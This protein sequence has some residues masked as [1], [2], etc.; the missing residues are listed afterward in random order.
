MK[1]LLFS[2]PIV[3]LLIGIFMLFLAYFFGGN[4]LFEEQ[5]SFNQEIRPIL[6]K[7]CLSCHGGVRKLGD[8]SLLFE[9]EAFSETESGEIAIVR[10]N[11]KASEVFKRITHHDPEERMPQKADP[12]S[13]EE[14]ELIAKWI[15]QGAKWEEHW[16]YIPPTQPK[17]PSIR[18]NWTKDDI[19]KYVLKALQKLDLKPA[20]ATN[21]ATYLRRASLDLTGLPPT[22][23]A[24]EA[25]LQDESEDAFEKAIDALLAS[26]HYGERWAAMWLDLARYADSQGY[27]KDDHRT[28][29]RYR[30]WVIQAFNQDMPFDQFTIEQLAGDLLEKPS[31]D[32]LVATGFHRNTM[33][34]AEGGT[35]D[36]EFRVASVIDRVN[37]TFELWQSSTMACVQ[38]HSH[39][40]DPIRHEEYYE[41]LDIFNQT[42][43]ADL[44]SE[45]PLLK[46]FSREDSIQV[47]E[48]IDFLL[49]K[50]KDLEVDRS[51]ILQEQITQA[52]FPILRP[53]QN[54]D[55]QNT[56]F[57]RGSG[58]GKWDI[59]SNQA[60]NL[61]AI[62]DNKFRLLFKDIELD[63]LTDITLR[64]TAKGTDS[65]IELRLD[66]A[67]GE[68]LAEINLPKTT[69]Q[70]DDGFGIPAAKIPIKPSQGKH[71]L[72]FELINTTG[73]IPDGIVLLEQI[74]LHYAN[75]YLASDELRT[76]KL[77]L[78][79]LKDQA[80]TA[81]IML[82]KSKTFR[83]ATKVFDR[84]N[85]R[86]Q[87]E[88]VQSGIPNAFAYQ[89][90]QEPANRLAFA[91]WLV[92]KDNPLTAR[93]MA[94]RIW[95][96][97]FGTGIIES[98]EDLGT[99]S[100]T[101]SH[102]ELLDYLAVQFQDKHQWGMK[103]FLKQIM[104]SATYRQSSKTTP[105]KLEKDPYNRYFSRGP[106]FRLSAEQIRDQALAVS[107]LL[108]DTIG[109]PSVMPH[110][111]DGVWQVVY[112]N[113]K[114]ITPKGKN[115]YRRG[116]YTYWKRTAPYPSMMAFDSP[117]REVCV[118]RRI[119]T[120]TPLQ[121]LV[122]LNDPVYLEAAEALAKKMQEA[123]K[124]NL[125]MAIQT[126][127]QL[128]LGKNPDEE[129][130][131]ILKQLYQQAKEDLTLAETST[132]EVPIVKVSQVDEQQ[133]S[134]AP[135]YEEIKHPMTVVANAIMNLDGFVMKE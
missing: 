47:A 44:S 58:D 12:L 105:E 74:E 23:S 45:Q 95:E 15:D 92:S 13:Q 114:W 79:A 122:T 120:N 5:V 25:F 41:T 113:A 29:W 128:A 123:G 99:Q 89:L 115:R 27:E 124:E 2:K 96:Q 88:A 131:D 135:Y 81:Q 121:A 6:N 65:R 3:I 86:T 14:I 87:T 107:G 21:K 109:G 48:I 130:I 63:G 9:E 82:P 4:G 42:V 20:E 93:V 55:F 80:G 108:H 101:A 103:Q 61:Q 110:Q 97:I 106:R 69:A 91:N 49:D 56:V 118:S 73:A 60:M 84:G 43:D 19:D 134:N 117:S 132:D 16:A 126:G 17:P 40:Y 133:D 66:D 64:F 51:A 32:Q 36:E 77:E 7:N 70:G 71:D 75:K 26:P 10:G 78:L 35:E 54:D 112:S 1:K 8:F 33:T 94:N 68:L 129:T 39:P 85:W 46:I 59:A 22:P 24:L 31:S 127:Y 38:C 83:R 30:D 104:L 67:E 90:D 57:H 50:E 98:L 28:A 52:L 116:L 119:R 18:S 72:I 53:G 100:M 76:K 102:P 62:R 37:T 11:A 34:N 125:G 111:P